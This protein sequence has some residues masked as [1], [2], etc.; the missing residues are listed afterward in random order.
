MCLEV[1]AY[2]SVSHEYHTAK[3][4]QNTNVLAHL[5]ILF[6]LLYTEKSVIVLNLFDNTHKIPF[7]AA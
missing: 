5:D 2:V 1:F 7:Q 4:I 6:I 3:Q